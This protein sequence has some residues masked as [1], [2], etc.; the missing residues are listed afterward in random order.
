M[1]PSSSRREFIR[2]ATLLA[3]SA[4]LAGCSAPYVSRRRV[5]GANDRLNVACVAVGAGR[6][7]SI[8]GP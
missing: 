2:Q 4:A 7:R 8:C 3:G 6:A 1:I 5:L